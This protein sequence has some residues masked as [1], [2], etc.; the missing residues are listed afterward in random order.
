MLTLFIDSNIWLALYHFTEDDLKSFSKLEKYLGREVRLIVTDQV[1][2]EVQRNREPKIADAFKGF[3]MPDIK[4][5]VF[6]R[7]Y[8]EF[9][10][11]SASYGGLKKDYEAWRN[12]IDSD[13]RAKCTPADETIR[14]LFEKAERIHLNEGIVQRGMIRS[15]RG[16][17]PG[18]KGS[19]GDAIN[20]ECLLEHVD[21]GNDLYIISAD[22]DFASPLYKNR[23]SQCLAEEWEHAKASK[24]YLYP[25][26]VSFLRNH[27][28]TINLET[29]REKDDLVN[30]LA[31]C[32]NF[33]T[34]HALIAKL[35]TYDGWSERQIADLC[36]AAR[37]TQV[38]WIF[39]DEDIV[40]FYQE[41]LSGV[42]E[43]DDDDNI[44]FVR[45]L[46]HQAESDKR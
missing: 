36:A 24:V 7:S 34:T 6:C 16:N 9:E 3:S 14:S 17:P 27:L 2:Y 43:G 33:A 20:W 41:V 42:E 1:Y 10:S 40:T 44:G 13:I 8:S 31:E 23:I 45:E 26:L 18:K 15:E 4:Y 22:R 46:I 30:A 35:K 19:C 11:F 39:E 29:E 38:K 5:P 21:K 28:D 12:K 37:N 32:R 25:G